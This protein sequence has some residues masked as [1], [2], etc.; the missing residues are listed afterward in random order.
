MS[1]VQRHSDIYCSAI[2]HLPLSPCASVCGSCT[3]SVCFAQDVWGAQV[4]WLAKYVWYVH[5]VWPAQLHRCCGVVHGGCPSPVGI[6]TGQDLGFPTP[7]FGTSAA[8]GPT[9]RPAIP[10]CVRPCPNLPCSVSGTNLS[11]RCRRRHH[12][13]GVCGGGGGGT[14]A[15]GVHCHCQSQDCQMVIR[16][17]QKWIPRPKGGGWT[18]PIT[19]QKAMRK[20]SMGGVMGP[21]MGVPCTC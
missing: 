11:W 9:T 2:F 1:A 17:V 10:A 20:K 12:G 19:P 18:H 7:G 6:R 13:A 16:N 8:Q 21:L 5:L 4:V 14:A 15:V 3:H